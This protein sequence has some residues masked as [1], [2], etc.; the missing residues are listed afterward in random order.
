MDPRKKN[1]DLVGYPIVPI[2]VGFAAWIDEGNNAR[3]TSKVLHMEKI[4]KTE[5]RFETENTNYCLRIFQP[6]S[7]RQEVNAE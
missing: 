1:I 6:D 3:R 2:A 7:L 5:I 4:S